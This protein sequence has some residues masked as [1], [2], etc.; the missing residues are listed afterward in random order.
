MNNKEIILEMKNITKIFPGV[1]AL[2][3]VELTLHKGESLALIGEN[4]A[5]KSTLMKILLGSYKPDGG[6]MMLKGEEYKPH[7]P[8]YALSKGISM[9]HQELTLVPEMTVSENI[10]IGREKNFSHFGIMD[11]KK[12]AKATKKLLER[13]NISI[14]PNQPVAKLSVANMQLVEIARAVS[15]DSDIIIMDEPTSALTNAEI[16]KLY[17][18]IKDLL[19]NDKS[20]IFISHKLEELYT[21]C[22]T[23]TV[24]RDGQYVST[25]DMKKITQE[26]LIRLMVG[27]KLENLYPKAD[28]P[29]GKVALE[30]KQLTRKG[31]FNNIS[32][33][34]HKGEILGFCGLMGAGRTEI[35]QSIFGIDPVDSGEIY[36]YGK[37]IDTS[38]TKK[39]IENGLA[40]VT[41]DRLRR[42][43]I[44]R[45]SVRENISL[46]YLRE[47]SKNGFIDFQQEHEDCE[48]TIKS[49]EIK[50]A[51]MEQEI[52]SLSGGNQQK[53]IIGKWLLT[54]PEVLILDEPTRGIDVGSKSEIYK[55]IGELAGQGKAIIIVSSELPEVMGISDRIMVIRN[56][57]IVAHKKRGEFDQEELMSH[58]FGVN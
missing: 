43:A 22:E 6:T 39:S 32:F 27:R 41:E 29:I 51:S 35:M 52:G 15:Y 3:N 58:A 11:V 55:L 53:A 9:I 45:L 46:A 57:E 38:S 19:A 24:L 13:L 14:D 37:P 1:K 17:D 33:D 2:D 23:I 56:G 12:R 26:E 48:Q 16:D 31:Y 54:S 34:V 40:M 5:G 47:I 4:G 25:H 18:I 30:V 44:H 21:I 8:A 42:G 50:V 36:L 7:T 10:W 20:V 28:V 49:M